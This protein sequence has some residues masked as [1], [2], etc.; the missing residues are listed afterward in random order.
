MIYIYIY[1]IVGADMNIDARSAGMSMFN[2]LSVAELVWTLYPR[3]FALHDMSPECGV[4]DL[5]GQVKLPPMIRT[6]YDRLSNQGA[7][8]VDTGNDLYF[9]LGSK[10]S[11]EFLQQVFAVDTLDAVDPNM[12]CFCS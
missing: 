1:Q 9:W 2:T 5:K 6:S 11:S 12:V 4:S 10:V 7:Y 8:F 3:M